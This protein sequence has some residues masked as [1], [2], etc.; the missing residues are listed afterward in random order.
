MPLPWDPSQTAYV[1]IDALQNYL[2]GI[3]YGDDQARFERWWPA[4]VHLMAKD[5]LWFHAVIWPAMLISVGL[6]PPRL[7]FA[8]GF[9]TI[10]GQKLS[11]SLGNAIPPAAL[12]ERYGVDA[13]RYLLLALFPFGVDGDMSEAAMAAR[14]NADLANDLGNLLNR[15]VSM[16]NRY[17]GG[18]VPF[19]EGPEAVGEDR[20]GVAA[21]TP[22]EDHR[23]ER[24]PPGT[25]G[26]QSVARSQS[27]L[28]AGR[29]DSRSSVLTGT[30]GD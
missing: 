29:S 15:T 14:Y 2:T 3:G 1:W 6:P 10:N 25:S 18:A 16:V 9:F 13:T 12:V 20:G 27:R 23:G 30:R 8:H 7:V 5:I 4:D 21:A 28:R 17:F 19:P 11:K 22:S 26:S 24:P